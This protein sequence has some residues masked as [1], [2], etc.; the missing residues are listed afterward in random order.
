MLE[1]KLFKSLLLPSRLLVVE[2]FSLVLK[3]ASGS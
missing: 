2:F 1:S 3:F